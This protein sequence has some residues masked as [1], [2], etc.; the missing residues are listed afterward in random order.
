MKMM[1]KIDKFIETLNRTNLNAF[2]YKGHNNPF[3]YCIISKGYSC[4][5][6]VKEAQGDN[7]GVTIEDIKQVKVLLK[8]RKAGMDS[9]VLI[10]WHR[11]KTFLRCE[12]ELFIKKEINLRDCTIF[13]VDK[14]IQ[15]GGKV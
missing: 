4:V 2:G 15:D 6:N 5:F 1:N 14:A 8:C 12:L 9:F 3:D 7:L 10:Y 11:A 13:H